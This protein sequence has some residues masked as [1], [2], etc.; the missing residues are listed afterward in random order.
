[1][2]RWNGWGEDVITYPLPETAAQYLDTRIGTGLHL[3]DASLERV[4]A[5][6]PAS[7]LSP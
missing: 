6:I 7:R 2:R 3:E 1:M 4:L 5:N